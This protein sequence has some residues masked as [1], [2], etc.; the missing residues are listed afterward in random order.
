MPQKVQRD[1]YEILGV[2]RDAT[3]KEIKHAYRRL[4]RLYHPDLNP[5]KTEDEERFKESQEAYEVLSDPEKRRLYDR[6]GHNRRAAWQA[7]QQGIDVESTPWVPPPKR[8]LNHS[9]NEPNKSR[10]SL[11]SHSNPS[12]DGGTQGVLSTSMPCC[13]ACQA[14][15]KLSPKRS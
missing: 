3:D 6:F 14:A 5:S 10:Q 12:L 13:F 4:V 1:Y 15:R 2:S 9:P 11:N 7:K 8:S